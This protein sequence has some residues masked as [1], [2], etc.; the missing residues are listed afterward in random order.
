MPEDPDAGD[1]AANAETV[2]AVV[3]TYNRKTL[4]PLTIEALKT[5]T[6]PLD[7]IIAVDNAST[8]GTPEV[9]RARGVLDD[10]LIDYVRMETNT[11]GAGGF[12]EGMKRAM[13]AGADWIWVMDDDVAPAPDC[14]EQLLKWRH[15]SQCL[16]PRKLY[17]DGSEMSW[18]T[19]LDVYTGGQ[20]YLPCPSFRN[21]KAIFFTNVGCFEGLLIARRIFAAIGPPDP[22][23]FVSSDDTLFGF[24]ASSHTNVSVVATATLHKLLDRVGPKPSWKDYYLTRN[25]FL[26]FRD[27]CTYLDLNPTLGH[28][29][30]FSTIRALRMVGGWARR[31]LGVW[32]SLH[33]FLD[34]VRCVFATGP[35]P[36]SAKFDSSGD[37]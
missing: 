28:K 8:D 1:I 6:R 12:H 9:L 20:T 13:E 11:G 30:Y 4:A 32:A 25:H 36:S 17:P 31:E 15:I 21:G 7:R 24:K 27:I 19:W 29:L 33:G 5:Q 34:G 35:R 18:E 16:H 22:R 2:I 37:L 14:L 26:L 10:P 23:Y 3:V